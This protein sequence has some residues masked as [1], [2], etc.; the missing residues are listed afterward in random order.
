MKLPTLIFAALK[1]G[2]ILSLLFAG[3]AGCSDPASSAGTCVPGASQACT[4]A[5]GCSGGQTCNAEGT[6]YGTCDCGGGVLNPD[7]GDGAD[8]CGIIKVRTDVCNGQLTR[9]T[10]VTCVVDANG[11][12]SHRPPDF[13]TY[14]EDPTCYYRNRFSIYRD[15]PVVGTCDEFNR[16]WN[17]EIECFADY[18]CRAP[19][20]NATCEDNLCVCPEGVNCQ[21]GP[22]QP[23]CDGTTLVEFNTDEGCNYYEVRTDCSDFGAICNPQTVAC[24]VQGGGGM[25]DGGI[26]DGGGGPGQPD[27]NEGPGQPGL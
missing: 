1:S 12:D 5:A 10:T 8:V 17:D 13:D 4:G 26:P 15:Q 9:T 23:S 16:W 20:G 2:A 11:C 25:P 24:E 7:G 21:C 22:R 3:T 18:Q 14:D 19:L 27:A 6:A